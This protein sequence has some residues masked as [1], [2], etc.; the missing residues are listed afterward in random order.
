MVPSAQTER[1]DHSYKGTEFRGFAENPG[2]RTVG[3]ELRRAIEIVFGE[4]VELTVAGRTDAGV[5]ATGQDVSFRTAGERPDCERLRDSLNGICSSEIRIQQV[6]VASQD[7]DAR[8]SATQRRYHYNILNSPAADPLR[9]DVEWH[10][11]EKLDVDAMNS[12]SN[13][14]LGEHDFTSFCRRPKDRPEQPLIRRISESQWT[15][16]PKQRIQFVV[17]ANAFCHQMVRS[18]TGFCVAV[19][20]G[21]RSADEFEA[22]L[23]AKDRSAAPP[24]APPHGLTLMHVT[25]PEDE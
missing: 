10:I 6:T 16:Q 7:F 8:F 1:I 17:A 15:R 19:G 18:L 20:L 14:F 5:H 11:V 4:P 22:V 3:A 23:D 24:I 13:R 25:Y 9:A 21:K 12:A 2:V